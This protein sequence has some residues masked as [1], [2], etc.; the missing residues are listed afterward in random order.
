MYKELN[1][2]ILPQR[3]KELRATYGCK[4]EEVARAL[5]VKQSVV[6]GHERGQFTPSLECM[7]IYA[8][9]YDISIDYLVGL[10]D[11]P[12]S[13]ERRRG[14]EPK[15]VIARITNF[16]EL[17]KE[18]DKFAEYIENIVELKLKSELEKKQGQGRS[19]KD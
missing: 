11:A 10:I 2:E 9:F 15:R 13:Y 6:S 16:E 4:Q 14:E 19:K 12:Y 17:V 8:Q 1:K 18:P 5:N 7:F 3:L